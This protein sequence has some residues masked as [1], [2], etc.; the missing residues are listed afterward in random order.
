M[1][2]GDMEDEV[3]RHL[4]VA[5]ED[6]D[7]DVLKVGHHGSKTSSSESFLSAVSPQLA[8]I[9]VGAKNRYGHPAA[10]V[11]DR[12]SNY[13]IKYYR[14]DLNGDVKLISDGTN[15]SISAEK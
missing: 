11:L 3:E 8:V 12:L 2:T 14:T 10:D 1:L 5:G 6:L 9:S 13:G 4:I 7:A 15:Y